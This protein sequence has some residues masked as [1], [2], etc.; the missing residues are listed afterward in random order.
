M[1]FTSQL[2]IILYFL[3]K[4][5]FLKTCS[6]SRYHCDKCATTL[7]RCE[8]FGYMLILVAWQSYLPV[9]GTEGFSDPTKCDFDF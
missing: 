9:E 7:I 6:L 4:I 2:K 5:Y 3:I 1:N 8:Q